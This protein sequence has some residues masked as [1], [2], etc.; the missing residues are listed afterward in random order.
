MRDQPRLGVFMQMDAQRDGIQI[1][2][3][4]HKPQIEGPFP[5]PHSLAIDESTDKPE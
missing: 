4:S 2:H 5:V 3:I 1:P